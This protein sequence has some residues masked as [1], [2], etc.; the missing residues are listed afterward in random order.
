ILFGL[1]RTIGRNLRGEGRTASSTADCVWCGD[2]GVFG[3]SV[4]IRRIENVVQVLYAE[5][6]FAVFQDCGVLI[7]STNPRSQSSV[8]TASQLNKAKSCLCVFA[9]FGDMDHRLRQLMNREG[10]CATSAARAAQV[11]YGANAFPANVDTGAGNFLC[12][13]SQGERI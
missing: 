11:E 7:D 13:L 8:G 10:S 2:S 4:A 12:T 6:P 3:P 5:L 9:V 1:N